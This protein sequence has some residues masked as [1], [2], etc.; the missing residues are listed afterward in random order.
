[1]QRA[2][3]VDR[4]VFQQRG[5]RAVAQQLAVE[6]VGVARRLDDVAAREDEAV[7]MDDESAARSARAGRHG[8]LAAVAELLRD[9]FEAVALQRRA[10]R[11]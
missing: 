11:L 8:E 6:R 7:G 1:M 10:D 4:K 5:D 9:R 2:E 3:I